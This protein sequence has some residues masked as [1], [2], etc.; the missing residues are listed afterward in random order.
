MAQAESSGN[1]FPFCHV[2]FVNGLKGLYP[3]SAACE[4]PC[5][6]AKIREAGPTLR[7][8][9]GPRSEGWGSCMGGTPL[10]TQLSDHSEEH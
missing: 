4:C 2:N 7:Q 5:N 1:L 8:R 10:K 6:H 9:E 3:E